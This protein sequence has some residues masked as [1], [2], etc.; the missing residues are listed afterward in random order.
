MSELI[1]VGTICAIAG[2]RDRVVLLL[3]EHRERCLRTE[4]GTVSFQILTADE[5]DNDIFVHE[6]YRDDEAFNRHLNGPS[7]RQWQ[8]DVANL[9]SGFTLHQARTV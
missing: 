9:L 2:E 7:L 6:V 8:S 4:E 3:Q 1:I 5:N